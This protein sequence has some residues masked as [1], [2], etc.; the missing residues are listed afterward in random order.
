MLSP[1]HI[2]SVWSAL[3]YFF[4]FALTIFAFTCLLLSISTPL[5]TCL[6]QSLDY[7]VT[8]LLT[9]LLYP[10]CSTFC[11]LPMISCSLLVSK[12]AKIIHLH[13]H[14]LDIFAVACRTTP[15]SAVA[16]CL[17]SNHLSSH[18][19]WFSRR[20][21]NNQPIEGHLL[22]DLTVLEHWQWPRALAKSA[23]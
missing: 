13:L 12:S 4:S 21:S 10:T 19:L 15:L 23:V 11:Y 3:V 8:F 22:A 16:V 18:F 5:S 7:L 9:S 1:L 20:C 14:Y 17:S 2:F 6:S